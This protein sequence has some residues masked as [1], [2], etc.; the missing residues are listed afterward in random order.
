[1]YQVVLLLHSREFT[2]I[3]MLAYF[4][5]KADENIVFLFLPFYSSKKSYQRWDETN[6]HTL[7]SEQ[8][9]IVL[10]STRR[11]KALLKNILFHTKHTS[12]NYASNRD[13]RWV[14]LLQWS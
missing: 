2:A 11:K 9:Q 13:Y 12:S 1:M 8:T 5:V 7:K 3:Y 10:R 6:L 14:V 4:C